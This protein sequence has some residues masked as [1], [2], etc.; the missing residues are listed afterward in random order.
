MVR[1]VKLTIGTLLALYGLICVVVTSSF[2]WN[3]WSI[4]HSADLLTYFNL[5]R[6][7]VESL[8]SG[9]LLFGLTVLVCSVAFLFLR[10][11]DR[12]WVRFRRLRPT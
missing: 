8:R 5:H 7:C 3:F 1:Y 6:F 12:R 9:L 4:C 10:Y 11:R 2:F